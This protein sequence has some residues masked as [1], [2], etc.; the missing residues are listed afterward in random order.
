MIKKIIFFSLFFILSTI[1][2][3][4]A[5]SGSFDIVQVSK[6][7]VGQPVKFEVTGEIAQDNNVSFEWSFSDNISSILIGKGGRS[8]GLI[9]HNTTPVA[10]NIKAV[11][12]NGKVLSESFLMTSA[13]LYDVEIRL[14][15]VTMIRLWDI[16]THAEEEAKEFA[17]NQKLTFESYISP[18][19]N[20]KLKYQWKISEG[21]YSDLPVDKK[22]ISVWR[23]EPGLCSIE[24]EVYNINGILLGK[25]IALEKVA[26]SSSDINESEDNK[27]A[28][29]KW[30]EALNIWNTSNFMNIEGYEKALDSAREALK[31]SGKDPEISKGTEKMKADN[32]L[33]QRARKY[34][35]EGKEF[36]ERSKWTESLASYRR[37]LAIWRFQ[38]T[39]KA[40]TEVEEIVRAIRIN[41]EKA[42]W[43]RDMARA[44][45][46]EKRFEDAIK[47]YEESLL[48]DKQELA[49]KGI[50]FARIS[51][52]NLNLANTLNIEAENLISSKDYSAAVD[53]LKESLSVLSDDVTKRKLTDIEKL[54][55]ELKTKASQLKSKGNEHAKQGRIAEALACFVE[56]MNLWAD[57]STKEL[58]I[59]Y[60]GIVPVEQRLSVST[61]K[62]STLV[63]DPEAA[64]LLKEG[65]EFY[66]AGDYNEAIVR[67][68]KSY[69]IESNQQLK[70]WIERIE[71]SMRAQASINESNRLIR[72]GNAL[73]SVGRY[74][75][76]LECYMSSLELYPNIEIREFI[77]HIEGILNK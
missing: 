57:T 73:Y 42:T 11:S 4:A 72:E 28:W 30:S 16:K 18:D 59:K 24:V 31:I 29:D 21:V 52:V 26:I 40:I 62:S 54:I 76:A 9:V 43:L 13:V 6:A 46:E 71:G 35:L 63:N 70:E 77:K 27:K 38:E 50:E 53:K 8:C 74:K 65:T 36:Q 56:S 41:R 69:E 20:E 2:H 22:N 34:V 49:I 44:Y 64:R 51:L 32:D 5:F 58:I 19:L 3:R 47:S 67:Y 48:L 25:G 15:P 33:I 61:D 45:E 10:I 55:S 12:E 68:K 39:E 60:E 37:S 17:V 23:E 14:A 66:R 1:F 75:E 7:Y